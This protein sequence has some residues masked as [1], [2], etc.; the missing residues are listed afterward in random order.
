MERKMVNNFR[1]L[2][3]KLSAP[4]IKLFTLIILT[5][6][7]VWIQLPP[8]FADI[9]PP[10]QPPGSNISPEAETQVQMVAE[11]VLLWVHPSIANEGGV[12][13]SADY[14]MQNRG[15]EEERMSVRFPLQHHDAIGEGGGKL[16]QLKDFNVKVNQ[17]IVPFTIAEEPFWEGGLPVNWAKFEVA[18][19]VEEEVII[20]VEYRAELY[21]YVDAAMIDYLLETGAGW[22]G[23]IGS[24]AIT[25]RL[26]YAASPTNVFTDWYNE[27]LGEATFVGNEVRWQCYSLEPTERSNFL[28]RMVWPYRWLEI[29]EIERRVGE[30]PADVELVVN[31]A[32]A[33]R[34]VGSIKG[35]YIESIY[36]LSENIILQGLALA[37][38]EPEYHVQLAHLEWW[39]L[40]WISKEDIN[41]PG[42]QLAIRELKL[43]LDEDP[44]NQSA[45]DLLNHMSEVIGDFELPDQVPLV[46]PTVPTLTPFPT[47]TTEPSLTPRPTRTKQPTSTPTM[48]ISTQ[49]E[50]ASTPTLQPTS[51]LEDNEPSNSDS[52][53]IATIALSGLFLV[54]GLGV[55]YWYKGQRELHTE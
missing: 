38:H 47:C 1:C 39:K 36:S 25:L 24:V 27:D 8:A 28:G 46:K 11:N 14:A 9:A 42:V 50:T 48:I 51:T 16:P 7:L 32:E 53:T 20:S 13:V 30:S 21:G 12:L 37:P 19:P 52:G 26:P 31:L 18:F 23:P 49:T 17:E 10:K 33:Y 3:G 4:A 2:P 6:G 34:E 40:A 45:L 5:M 35:T 44:N 29:L 54:V 22:Y 55:G 15:L 41:N 43:A